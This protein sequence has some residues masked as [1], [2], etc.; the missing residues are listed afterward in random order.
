MVVECLFIAG[1]ED[2]HQD[3]IALH[4]LLRVLLKT[5]NNS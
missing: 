4:L 5:E 2:S 1:L 3:F